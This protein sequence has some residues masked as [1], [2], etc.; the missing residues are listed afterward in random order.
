MTFEPSE[1]A[2]IQIPNFENLTIDFNEIDTLIRKR[3]IEKVLDIVDEALLVRHH[4]FNRD[5]V[6]QMRGIWKKLSQRR[7]NRKK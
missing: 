6:E 1:I 3:E 5:E 4:G 7:I 2:E